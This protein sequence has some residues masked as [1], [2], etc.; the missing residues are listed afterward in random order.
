[1]DDRELAR[2]AIEASRRAYA[3]Y[4]RFTVGAALLARGG[5]VVEGCNVENASY[6]LTICAERVAAS[7]AV[8]R[9]LREFVAIAV[10]TPTRGTP[11]GA[12][13]QFLAEF[14][15]ELRVVLTDLEGGIDVTDLRTLLPRGFRL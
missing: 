8:A 11:C 1:M 10:A 13:R 3:P 6:G 14:A 7:A 15:P 2:R 12:C 9:G 4:S 5:E